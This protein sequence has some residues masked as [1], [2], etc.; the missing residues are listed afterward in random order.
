M[1]TTDIFTIAIDWTGGRNPAY[2]AHKKWRTTEEKA[3]TYFANNAKEHGQACALIASDGRI[4][5]TRNAM[6]LRMR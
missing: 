3:R 1:N 2:E 5:E 4:V 6:P